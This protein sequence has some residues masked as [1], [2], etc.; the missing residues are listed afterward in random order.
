VADSTWAM[1]NLFMDCLQEQFPDTVLPTPGNFCLLPGELMSED[2]DPIIGDDL[3]C[4]G[5]GWVRIGNRYPSSSFP[6]AD[7][8]LKGCLPVGWAQGIEVG[9]LGCYHPGGEPAMATCAEKTQE[10]EYDMARIDVLN[11][12]ACCF[13]DRLRADPTTRGRLWTVTSIDVSGPRGNCIS[14]VMSTLVQIGKCC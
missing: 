7:T 13:Q 12:V 11:R 3:C 2:I 14:R 4:E 5:L 9:L 8:V 10:A 1:A 6:T